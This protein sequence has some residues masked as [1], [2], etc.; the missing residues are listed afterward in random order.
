MG[1]QMQNV[2][3][4][5]LQQRFF[6]RLSSGEVSRLPTPAVKLLD[7]FITFVLRARLSFRSSNL[8]HPFFRCHA[9]DFGPGSEEPLSALA[10][11]TVE[12]R[13]KIRISKQNDFLSR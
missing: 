5:D 4:M 8:R 7:E 6:C 1:G 13:L 12:P 2:G 11:N 9:S 3:R 10:N